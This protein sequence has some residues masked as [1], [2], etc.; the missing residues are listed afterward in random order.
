MNAQ[1]V[2]WGTMLFALT[3]IYG[4]DGKNETNNRTQDSQVRTSEETST[5]NKEVNFSFALPRHFEEESAHEEENELPPKHEGGLS[6][7][8]MDYFLSKYISVTCEDESFVDFA[9]MRDKKIRG[10]LEVSLIQVEYFQDENDYFT[11]EEGYDGSVHY[12]LEE[13]GEIYQERD[14]EDL[15]SEETYVQ[16]ESW[17]Y[18]E[19]LS[20]PF[21]C[22]S[23]ANIKITNLASDTNYRVDARLYS[24]HEQL[25]YAG[26]TGDFDANAG[27]VQLVMQKRQPDVNI[28]VIFEKNKKPIK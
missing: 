18:V 7:Q 27:T 24:K 22:K 4:C 11:E 15:E 19:S 14:Y 1:R 5:K 17:N 6:G 26:S 8:F 3:G 10:I 21:I 23:A 25:K 28:E 16:S 2:L 12:V 13:D 20:I 9:N